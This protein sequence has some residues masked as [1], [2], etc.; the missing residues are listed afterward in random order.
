MLLLRILAPADL[1]STALAYLEGVDDVADL[2]HLPGA[3]R[4]P[5]GDL[6]QC[7][8]S[9]EH[10]SAVVSAMTELG[11]RARG[12][13]TLDRLEG[14]VSAAPNAP[15]PDAVVW[16]EVESKAGSMAALSMSYLVYLIAATVLA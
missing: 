11:V 7:R 4:K 10:A 16:E 15:T 9:P 2:V 13:I 1:A 14:T 5:R 12:S 6:I 8:V 3:C